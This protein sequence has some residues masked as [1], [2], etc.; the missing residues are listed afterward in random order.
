MRTLVITLLLLVLPASLARANPAGE[1]H[2]KAELLTCDTDADT[3][4]FRGR[5][6][7]T[8]KAA[9][10]Q[11]RFKLQAR[12][13]G[14]GG[15]KHVVAPEGSTFDTWLSSTPGK[16][17][18]VYD[19]TV[20]NLEDGASYRAVVRFRWRDGDGH[21]VARAIKATKAC[22]QPDP[23]PNLKVKS[24]TAGP[25]TSAQTRTYVVRVVNRGGSEAPAF[26]TGLVVNGAT[27]ADR[28]AGPIAPGAD[29]R[30]GFAAPKCA[31]GSTLTAT[32]DTMAAVDE[33]NETDNVLAVP[34][35]TGGG[36]NG[37]AVRVD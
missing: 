14:G 9:S 33:R 19:K 13:P 30:I 18:Y 23:R 22:K 24:V 20:Q 26:A 36:R 12:V 27:L 1:R 31:E 10:L 21:T 17:G 7:T 34:C 3:A 16:K 32:A 6:T 35:P 25:G 37:R 5:M 11:L 15:F 28:P 2:S 29:A 8:R 4:T